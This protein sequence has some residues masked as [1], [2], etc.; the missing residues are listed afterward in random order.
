MFAVGTEEY[1]L[2]TFEVREPLVGGGG[3]QEKNLHKG[4][5]STLPP[6]LTPHPVR[7]CDPALKKQGGAGL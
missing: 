4:T 7:S 2:L 3:R 1:V 5:V 6:T